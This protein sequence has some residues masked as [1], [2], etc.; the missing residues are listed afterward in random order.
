MSLLGLGKV[1]IC[2]SRISVPS[3]ELY[4]QGYLEGFR[5]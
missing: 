5:F 4:E 3:S 1:I 2:F